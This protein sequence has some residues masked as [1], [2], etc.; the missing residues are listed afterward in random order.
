[1]LA[2]IQSDKFAV[3]LFLAKIQTN[4]IY[5]VFGKEK[6]NENSTQVPLL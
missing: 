2:T 3:L 1:M 4:F 6:T 5:S